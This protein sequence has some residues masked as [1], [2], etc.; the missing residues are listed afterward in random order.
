MAIRAPDGANK[1]LLFS[2]ACTLVTRIK[3]IEE[4]PI[5]NVFI[6]KVLRSLIPV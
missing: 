5:H 2:K 6:L 4:K 3:K 1:V